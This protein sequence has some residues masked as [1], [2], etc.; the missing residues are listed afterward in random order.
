MSLPDEMAETINRL[1]GGDIQDAIT[2]HQEQ[3]KRDCQHAGSEP[4]PMILRQ[5]SEDVRASRL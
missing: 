3:Y 5:I 2:A 4:D 1:I